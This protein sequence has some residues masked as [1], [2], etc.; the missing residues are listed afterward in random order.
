MMIHPIVAACGTAGAADG[1]STTDRR[2]LPVTANPSAASWER[3][4]EGTLLGYRPSLQ[5]ERLI[6]LNSVEKIIRPRNR[7]VRRPCRTCRRARGTRSLRFS[8]EV[9]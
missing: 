9:R 8:R 2:S 3:Q 4:T 6:G 5:P 7:H 1:E